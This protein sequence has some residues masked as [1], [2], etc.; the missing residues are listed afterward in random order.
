MHIARVAIENYRNFRSIDLNGLTSSLVLVGENGSGKSNFLKALRLV[1]DSSLPESS[2]KLIAEDFWD[3][4]DQPFAGNEIRVV[5]ELTGFDDDT[6]AK[7]VLGEW[8]VALSPH[9]ARLTYLYRPNV[10]EPDRFQSNESQ[11]EVVIFGG[12]DERQIVGRAQW[13]YISLRVLPALRDAES[14]LRS[15][16]SPL[17]RLL[18]RVSVDETVL[19]DV[20]ARINEAGEDLTGSHELTGVADAIADRLSLMV[21]DLFAVK[22]SLGVLSANSDQLLRSMRLFI[23]DERTRGIEQASLGTANLLYLTLLLEDIGAQMAAEEIVDL[24]LAVEEPE[25]HLHPHVQRILFRHLLREDRALV[26]TTHSAHVASVTPLN[27][28]VMLRESDGESHAYRATIQLA[29]QETRDLER[30]MDVT[31][32]EMLFAR[33]VI[34][35]EGLAELYLIPAFVESAGLNFD[36]YG[37]TVCSVHGTNFAP[38]V[39]LLGPDGL[40]VPTVVVTDGDPNNS[41]KPAGLV[42]SYRSMLTPNAGKVK[43]A[44]DDA[45]YDTA[46]SLAREQ[47]FMVGERTLEIDLIPTCQAAM[48]DAYNEIVDSVA[49]RKRFREEI[50]T[51]SSDAQAR[52]KLLRRIE[53]VG[54]GRFAQRLADHIGSVAPPKYIA[55]AIESVRVLVG[56]KTDANRRHSGE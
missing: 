4:L 50:S 40:N 54:K 3:G 56:A 34:L 48:C 32:A 6:N 51:A 49:R 55:D 25:A 18:D 41:G 21:G 1:L 42:R 53:R 26:V 28:L 20:V 8:L 52:Q 2:R 45:N 5:V 30:Y 37:V 16:R 35:V 17:R 24:I 14:Q 15:A 11:Y 22:T 46:R 23:N 38:Y 47:N 12:E 10:S 43:Q 7:A 33:I 31:R 19:T 29:E 39:R 13:R 44:T 9:K 27:S 36:A